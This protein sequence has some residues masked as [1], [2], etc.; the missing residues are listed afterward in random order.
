MPVAD[1]STS[2]SYAMISAVRADTWSNSTLQHISSLV[3]AAPGF[4]SHQ[5]GD[6]PTPAWAFGLLAF[7]IQIFCFGWPVVQAS[8]GLSIGHRLST[9]RKLRLPRRRSWQSHLL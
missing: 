5:T 2:G 6:P 1:M 4:R 9:A 7:R 3:R 8:T